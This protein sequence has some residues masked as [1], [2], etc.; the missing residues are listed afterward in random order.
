MAMKRLP[1]V[2]GMKEL[3]FKAEFIHPILSRD[4]V[5]T[6]RVQTDI[7]TGDIF[8]ATSKQFGIFVYLRAT[9]VERRTLGTFTE[10][11]AKREGLESLDDFKTVWNGLHPRKHFDPLTEVTVIQFR[12]LYASEITAMW[13][14]AAGV[15]RDG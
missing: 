14:K 7:E 1:N 10:D 13:K 9:D 8:A 2:E 12:P 3:K 15:D 4:K 11:D 6:A 5:Q